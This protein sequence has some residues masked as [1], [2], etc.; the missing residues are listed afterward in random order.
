[1]FFVFYLILS[2]NLIEEKID[3]CHMWSRKSLP[4]QST[5]RSLFILFLLFCLSFDLRLLITPWYLQTF[6]LIIWTCSGFQWKISKKNPIILVKN[7]NLIF[8]YRRIF[9]SGLGEKDI[10]PHYKL[11]SLSLSHG[12]LYC[13]LITLRYNSR[14][15]WLR[16]FLNFN[17]FIQ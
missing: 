12:V 13:C 14:L 4:F 1:M 11:N 3:G 8:V 10:A 17:I 2:P 5:C 16:M 15:I 9:F 7:G 6:Q